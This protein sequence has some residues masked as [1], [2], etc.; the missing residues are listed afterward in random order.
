VIEIR[1]FAAAEVDR[2]SYQAMLNTSFPSWGGEREFRW[3][4]ERSVAGQLPDLLVASENGAPLAGTAVVYRALKHAEGVTLAAIMS[5]ACTLPQA[6]RRGLL[7]QLVSAAHDAA[8][9]RGAQS[10]LAFVT[11]SNASARALAGAGATMIPSFY[12]RI[13]R[14]PGAALRTIEP[15]VLETRTAAAHFVYTPDEWRAQFIERPQRVVCVDAGGAS[16]ALVESCGGFDRIH[17]VADP[18]DLAA[19]EAL[20]AAAARVNRV[21][22]AYT[23]NESRARAWRGE[24]IDGF[25]CVL[26]EVRPAAWDLQNGDRI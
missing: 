17:A 25:L 15:C 3:T 26:G 12:C 16:H 2:P 4:F 20:A 9:D 1:R 10:F 19:I 21:A 5:A 14:Q 22:F 7:Q 24:I 11:A 8:R 6:R 18:D 23:T 13:S